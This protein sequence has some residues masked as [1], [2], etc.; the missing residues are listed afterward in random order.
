[1]RTL[2]RS[3]KVVWADERKKSGLC[4]AYAWGR[5]KFGKS[6]SL[7]LCGLVVPLGSSF[8]SSTGTARAFLATDPVV[9][10]TLKVLMTLRKVLV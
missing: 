2:S 10:A 7:V 8:T 9:T 1:M 6:T 3:L 4:R 5:S